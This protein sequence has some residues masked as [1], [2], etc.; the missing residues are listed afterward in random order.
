MPGDGVRESWLRGAKGAQ[1]VKQSHAP[2][3]A[4]DQAGVVPMTFRERGEIE[5]QRW[6]W[7]SL[8]TPIQKLKIPYERD[9]VC[10]AGMVERMLGA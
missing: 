3:V 1:A 6:L 2:E 7:W 4:S 9:P 8:L 5:A 10:A